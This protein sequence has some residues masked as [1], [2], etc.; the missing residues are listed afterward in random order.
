MVTLV[1]ASTFSSTWSNILLSVRLALT[2]FL[3]RNKSP[4]EEGLSAAGLFKFARRM[5]GS[6]LRLGASTWAFWGLDRIDGSGPWTFLVDLGVTDV[7]F[8][9]FSNSNGS[10]I[11]PSIARSNCLFLSSPRVSSCVPFSFSSS[12]ADSTAAVLLYSAFDCALL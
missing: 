4:K 6:K 9:S 12:I 11:R 1:N 2:D 3:V 5:G 7:S 10:S 8:P